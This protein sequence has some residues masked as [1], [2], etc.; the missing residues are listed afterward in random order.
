MFLESGLAQGYSTKIL[1][2]LIGEAYVGI[3]NV[4]DCGASKITD[5]NFTFVHGDSNVLLEEVASRNSHKKISVFI[6]GPKGEKAIALKDRILKNNKNVDFV[7]VHDTSSHFGFDNLNNHDA[8]RVFESS[9]NSEYNFKY[10]NIL[11]KSTSGKKDIFNF[12]NHGVGNGNSLAHL[13]FGTSPVFNP[14]T[15]AEHYPTGPG[16]AIYSNHE[17]NFEL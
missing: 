10:Y 1:L 15:Y 9:Q 16:I 8:L 17:I 14:K 13:P 7:G 12:K 11:N 4:S 3:D 2:S 6:D 5:N